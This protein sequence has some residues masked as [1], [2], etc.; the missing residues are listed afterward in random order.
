MK[1]NIFHAYNR[2]LA[3]FFFYQR[4]LTFVVSVY[5]PWSWGIQEEAD[6]PLSAKVAVVSSHILVVVCGMHNWIQGQVP[7]LLKKKKLSNIWFTKA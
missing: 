4:S 7:T 5:L 6:S 2:Y 3:F 1:R